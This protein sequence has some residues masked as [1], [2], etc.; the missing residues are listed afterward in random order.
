MKPGIH[1][2]VNKLGKMQAA[3]ERLTAKDV[4]VGIPATKSS[5]D[6]GGPLNNAELGYVHEHGAPE[7]NVP[8]RP[9]LRPGLCAALPRFKD[10]LRQAGKLAFAG[11]V[12][13]VDRALAAAGQVSADSVRTYIFAGIAPPLADSTVAARRRRS[14]GAKY[15]RKAVAASQTT[16]LVDTGEYARKITYVVREK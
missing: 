6:D 4:L 12:G 9:H 7:A 5:R 13:G 3:L 16:P 15:R 11:N 10:Y 8:A 14:K 2:T 1:M